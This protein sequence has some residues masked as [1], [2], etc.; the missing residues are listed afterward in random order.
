[1]SPSPERA[2]AERF[3]KA[4]TGSAD[5]PITF[6]TFAE[7]QGRGAA[8]IVHGTLEEKWSE[9]VALNEQGHG[10]FVMINEGDFAGRS[11]VNVTGLRAVFI[12]DDGGQS[13]SFT[14]PPSIVSRS[15]HGI[16]AYW[17]IIQ[18]ESLSRFTPA[19]KAL[20]SHFST[21]QSVHDLPRV[22]RCPGFLHRKSEP[23]LVRVE[24][25][26]DKAYTLDQV[27]G[28]YS[29]PSTNRAKPPPN[30]AR[31]AYAASEADR[32]GLA[33]RWLARQPPAVEG[34]HGDDW[35]FKVCASVGRGFDLTEEA[36]LEAL[37]DWNSLCKPPWSESELR[38]KIRSGR[39]SG[40]EEV[41]GRLPSAQ[42]AYVV[43]WEKYVYKQPGGAW[44]L[45]CPVGAPAIR[46]HIV[47]TLKRSPDTASQMIDLNGEQLLRAYGTDCEPGLPATFERDGFPHL[48]TYVPPTLDPREG[49]WPRVYQLL[50][51]VTEGPEER[52]YILNWC[53]FKVQHPG[54][55][56]GT[57]LVLQGAQ[58]TGKSTVGRI[59]SVMLGQENCAEI[60]QGDLEGQFNSH[61]APKLLVCVDE[62]SNQSNIDVL[63]GKLKKLITD[64]VA[65]VNSKGVKQYFVTNRASLIITSNSVTPVQL[66]SSGDR[67][68]SVFKRFVAPSPDE[69]MFLASLY[70]TGGEFSAP[71]VREIEAFMADLLSRKIDYQLVRRPFENAARSELADA[72]TNS[73]QAFCQEVDDRG[74]DDVLQS[75]Q[76]ELVEEGLP[77]RE[78]KVADGAVRSR[79]VY[80]AYRVC[81]KRSGCDHPVAEKRFNAE[82]S[83][84]RPSWK[85]SKLTTGPRC[86]VYR[87]LPGSSPPQA[88]TATVLDGDRL[89]G[90]PRTE[91]LSNSRLD[92]VASLGI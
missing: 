47:G 87:N 19:Q 3:I 71:F 46:A 81:S 89:V 67:R 27:L 48:N 84:C 14:L 9:L 11:A 33:K 68:Y 56:N 52:E 28:A 80:R 6:Q 64:G 26:N 62:A 57:A 25:A 1:M 92:A 30:E 82:L 51:M 78:W 65:V 39:T 79:V 69:K 66:A 73:V 16:H 32:Q 72:N 12:D 74:I 63:D 40:K 45:T 20:A 60:G 44:N 61:Y 42:I 15:A 8:Q 31:P 35:T 85:K 2:E 37:R 50:E 34:D 58:G 36:A 86:W 90:A 21:D 55:R 41:G 88:H 23:F 43:P 10:I 75:V 91:A 70:D 83:A 18:G 59:L 49:A 5:S 13:L 22:M 53:A 29:A 38:T 17:R 7:G 4:L 76:G 54:A 24:Q 77:P